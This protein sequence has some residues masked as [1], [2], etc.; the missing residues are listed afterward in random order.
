MTNIF[1]A[2]Y[3]NKTWAWAQES[4]G[5]FQAFC[6]SVW[7][8]VLQPG[9]LGN[10][11]DLEPLLRG[12]GHAHFTKIFQR[13]TDIRKSLKIL[14]QKANFGVRILVYIWV[15]SGERTGKGGCFN[16]IACSAQY[17]EKILQN[18][19]LAQCR[20]WEHACVSSQEALF[21]FFF[22][23]IAVFIATI[24]EVSM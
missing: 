8:N 21:W 20:I 12:L 23:D 22:L 5:S 18:S 11:R 3:V 7:L 1:L 9:L 13:N 14:V 19:N 10:S 4:D 2:N 15:Q 17:K 24:A 16:I 6:H